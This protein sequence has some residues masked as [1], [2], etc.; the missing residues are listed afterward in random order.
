MPTGGLF[1]AGTDTGVGKTR[2][3]VSV[4][5]ALIR[6]GLRV[7]AMKPVAAGAVPTAQGLRNGDAVSLA[8]AASVTAPYELVN[9]YCLAAPVSPHIAAAEAGVRI[10]PERIARCFRELAL[11]AD[12]V[13]VEGAGGWLAPI[14]ERATMADVARA[15]GLPVILVVGLRLGCLNHALLT[16][17]AI[18]ADGLRLAGWIANHIDP[19]L[20][21]VPEN[22][23]ALEQLLSRP[24][25]AVLPHEVLPH[26]VLPREARP[27]VAGLALE[28]GHE[29]PE[30]AR[31]AL[32]GALRAA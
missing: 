11:R 16:A 4:T 3:G 8:A 6:A 10:E 27:P 14:G 17:R 12:A 7:A 22:L 18:V 25:L 23:A 31:A 1:I 28:P 21:R 15:L 26:A 20:E 9:P 30:R 2:A 13:V 5:R 32:L 24:P 29:L 19:G